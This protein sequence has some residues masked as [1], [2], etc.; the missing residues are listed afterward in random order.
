MKFYISDLPDT[1]ME[2]IKKYIDVA[3]GDD[4][5]FE[6]LQS[7]GILTIMTNYIDKPDI[8]FFILDDVCYTKVKNT[9]LAKY[10]SVHHYTSDEELN[11]FLISQFGEIGVDIHDTSQG[12]DDDLVLGD[13]YIESNIDTQ[14]SNSGSLSES[15]LIQTYI[16]EIDE[17]RDE[18]FRVLGKVAKADEVLKEFGKLQSTLAEYKKKISGY[19]HTKLQLEKTISDLKVRL[20][21]CETTLEE[22]KGID[23]KYTNLFVEKENLK[24]TLAETTKLKDWS[25]KEARDLE[26]EKKTLV[27]SVKELKVQL[28]DRETLKERVST[29]TEQLTKA[30]DRLEKLDGATGVVA[31]LKTTV[32]ENNSDLQR[33]HSSIEVLKGRLSISS[34]E[35]ISNKSA[36]ERMT[37]QVTELQKDLDAKTSEC[38]KVLAECDEYVKSI[39]SLT[40]EHANDL[41]KISK[42]HQSLDA[43]K[44]LSSELQIKITG[45]QSKVQDLSGM[46]DT[47]Q[48]SLDKAEE[49]ILSLKSNND[50]L[51]MKIDSDF[52]DFNGNV[53]SL[54]TKVSSLTD[55]LV[56][57]KGVLAQTTAELKECKSEK[58][59]TIK[60]RDE[61]LN[62]NVNLVSEIN[63]LKMEVTSEKDRY[64]KLN[65]E[66]TKIMK[67]FSENSNKL[68]QTADKLKVMD[69]ENI[70]LKEKCSRLQKELGE[71]QKCASD[72]KQ[73]LNETNESLKSMNDSYR[74]L[75]SKEEDTKNKYTDK[76][77]EEK[78]NLIEK[79]RFRVDNYKDVLQEYEERIGGLNADIAMLSR[80]QEND[81][82]VEVRDLQSRL[83]N[84]NNLNKKLE[85][86]IEILTSQI[87]K[88]TTDEVNKKNNL[89]ELESKLLALKQE[90]DKLKE[91]DI[92]SQEELV[93]TLSLKKKLELASIEKKNDTKKIAELELELDT[94]KSKMDSSKVSDSSIQEMKQYL[95]EKEISLQEKQSIIDEMESSVFNIIGNRASAKSKMTI[96]I[97]VP[98][99]SFSNIAVIGSVGAGSFSETANVLYNLAENAKENTI[100]I[101]LTSES[102]LDAYLGIH[103]LHDSI[104]WLR[105]DDPI[106]KYLSDTKYKKVK[107]LT[108][109]STYLFEPYKLTVDWVSRL[110]ELGNLNCK[111]I[112]HIGS[113]DNT[114]S[115]ILF[116]SFRKVCRSYLVLEGSPSSIRGAIVNLKGYDNLKSTTIFCTRFKSLGESI[117]RLFKKLYNDYTVQLLESNKNNK[118]EIWR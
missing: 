85:K 38:E 88:F 17:L 98:D 75:Q 82:T 6:K 10:D 7:N 53:D 115:S 29:L 71:E 84:T 77:I 35:L 64:N 21:E 40:D 76:E 99:K 50:I 57:V 79:L 91:K 73:K 42:L 105:G 37:V 33:M 8:G 61:L 80:L 54:K 117:N 100:V 45:L 51:K 62:K 101:D 19:N 43:E 95:S 93:S 32:A 49:E 15:E 116:N 60:H 12:M 89:L 81:S 24:K 11:N 109:V 97:D 4:Y 90:N 13:S 87:E 39:N 83:E 118:I 102:K 78:D 28:A 1:S 36:N 9:K 70:A 48:A 65:S 114:I 44:K 25:E 56:A 113:I 23:K 27:K 16:K 108:L 52:K 63:S 5:T 96:N 47:K 86:Q 104:G 55:E 20:S 22:Y 30:T 14:S 58:E 41:D 112:I 94:V 66:A 3:Y 46:L 110:S 67:S 68:K 106:G 111:V 34:K 103:V 31:K 107:L 26:E 18:N 2:L 69:T 92:C 72:L 59:T 74:K